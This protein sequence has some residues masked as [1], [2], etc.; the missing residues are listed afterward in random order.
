MP[1]KSRVISIAADFPKEVARIKAETNV[2][3]FSLMKCKNIFVEDVTAAAWEYHRLRL[4][5]GCD[6]LQEQRPLTQPH[7]WPRSAEENIMD[8]KELM[9]LIKAQGE[10][11]GKGR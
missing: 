5:R 3:G 10:A 4:Y 2:L 1:L 11:T 9:E 6:S 8:A 7:Q